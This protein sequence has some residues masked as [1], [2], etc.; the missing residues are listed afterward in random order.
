[1]LTSP[2]VMLPFQID[3]AMTDPS[4]QSGLAKYV[5]ERTRDLLPAAGRRAAPSSGGWEALAFGRLT[6]PEGG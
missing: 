4:A 2:K 1:M 5:P 6:G 3:R